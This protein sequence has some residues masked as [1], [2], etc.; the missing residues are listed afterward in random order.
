L[1]APRRVIVTGPMS[2][3]GDLVLAPIAA[4]VRRR[5]APNA[6]PDIVLGALGTRNTA[7]GA[8]ALALDETDWLPARRP[9]ATRH[10]PTGDASVHW[11]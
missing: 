10:L 4:A 7:L 1:L 8:I 5:I 11:P 6:F 2:Q 3:A 9:R